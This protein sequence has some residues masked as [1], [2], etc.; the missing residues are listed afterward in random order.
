MRALRNLWRKT[1]EPAAAPGE[2]VYVIGDVHGR[3]DLLAAM[4]AELARHAAA[5]AP[6]ART[7]VVFVG[8]IIDRGPD[9]RK[10]LALLEEARHR[11]PE[12][13]TLL[14]NHEEMLLRSVAGDETALRNW[15]R[16][17]GAQTVESFGLAPLAEDAD[18]VPYV[19]ALRRAVPG[20]WIDWLKSWP[21][22][23]RSGD[24]FIVHAGVKAG[25]ALNRQARRDLLWARAGFV[26]NLHDHGSV[27]VHGHTISE[28]VE[29]H[30]NRIGI[31]TGAY[32]SGTLSAICL[33]GMRTEVLA[34]QGPPGEAY[35]E[36][37][38]PRP[39]TECGERSL[40]SG[41]R[42]I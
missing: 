15:M 5:S 8:D 40:A 42:L 37:P 14:G 33:E 38:D 28:A 26:D 16:F 31:D 29:L 4:L 25:V 23:E 12:L 18:A 21:L 27:I 20:A 32:R 41:P 36:A 1:S 3:A 6:V 30:P 10:A 2:R 34:V 24:Y 17:G 9:S 22:T 35:D 11:M 39:D 7:K 13:I 19:A